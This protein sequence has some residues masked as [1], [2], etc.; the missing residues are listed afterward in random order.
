[1]LNA[2]K[3]FEEHQNVLFFFCFF[4]IVWISLAAVRLVWQL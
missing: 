1:M 2:A 4:L 3:L